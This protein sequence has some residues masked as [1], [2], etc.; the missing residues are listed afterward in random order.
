[1]VFHSI[2]FR[3]IIEF[4]QE[5]DKEY[6]PSFVEQPHINRVAPAL[7]GQTRLITA[8]C[9][10]IN[11]VAG[12]YVMRQT[13]RTPT[14]HFDR[15][16]GRHRDHRGAIALLLPLRS[17]R[18]RSARRCSLMN[19]LE[20]NS[21]LGV[22]TNYESTV[23]NMFPIGLK[24]QFGN[25]TPAIIEM[26]W[27]VA[28]ASPH[29]NRPMLTILATTR[30]AFQCSKPDCNRVDVEFLDS[31]PAVKTGNSPRL[32]HHQLQVEHGN[33]AGVDRLQFSRQRRHVR[34][35]LRQTHCRYSRPAP[36]TRWLSPKASLPAHPRNS[37]GCAFPTSIPTR[38]EMPSIV[39][40]SY[41]SCSITKDPR[42]TRW[43]ERCLVPCSGLTI[44]LPPN[45]QVTAGPNKIRFNLHLQR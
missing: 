26:G 5:E 40:S 43:S 10:E 8:R 28:S 14:F 2:G 44:G 31:S 21:D 6:S 20:S 42:G 9:R 33:V 22:L 25:R 7:T 36:V 37:S 1:M 38:E 30:L 39:V 23:E 17:S 32:Q 13:R 29:G 19:N 34:R 27:G 12:R 35:E 4:V 16:A 3:M 24:C 41:G 45:T 15:T 18:S 11:R